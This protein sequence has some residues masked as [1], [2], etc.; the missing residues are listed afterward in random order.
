[1]LAGMFLRQPAE[2]EIPRLFHGQKET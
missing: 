1:V 2:E